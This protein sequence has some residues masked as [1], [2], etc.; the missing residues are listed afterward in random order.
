MDNTIKLFIC[1]GIALIA[2][3]I[4]LY[5]LGYKEGFYFASD[6]INCTQQLALPNPDYPWMKLNVTLPA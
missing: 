4:T 5:A 2:I 3:M 6:T 1:L